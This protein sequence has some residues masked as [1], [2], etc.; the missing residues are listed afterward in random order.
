MN[1]SHPDIDLQSMQEAAA[2]ACTLLKVLANPDRLL[3]MCQLSQGELSV[4]ALEVQLGIRQP[5]LSQQLTI[6]REKGLVS[7]R[8]DGKTIYYS[9]AS[10]QA[11]AVM[12]VLYQQFCNPAADKELTC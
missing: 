9:V 12:A 5:T 2:S 7:T 11:L 6:L 8:R 3:L 10:P 4:G 1:P